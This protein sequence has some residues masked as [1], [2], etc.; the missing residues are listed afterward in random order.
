MLPVTVADLKRI[1]VDRR[2]LVLLRCDQCGEENSANHGDYFQSP[3]DAIFMHC[4]QPMRL[5]Q[6]Q[7]VYKD[8]PRVR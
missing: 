2:P 6:K 4:R 7:V 5:V 3:P 1:D 8:E